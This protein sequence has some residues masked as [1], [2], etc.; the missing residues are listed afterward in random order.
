MAFRTA[1]HAVLQTVQPGRAEPTHVDAE[2]EVA[3]VQDY[4]EE[5]LRGRSH[6]DATDAVLARIRAI[7]P[8]T[9]SGSA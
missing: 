4:A 8:R 5:R 1:F 6:R 9:G 7:A 2:G 3:W